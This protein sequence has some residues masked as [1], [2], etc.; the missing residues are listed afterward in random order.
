MRFALS[1]IAV[2][3]SL[4]AC[5]GGDGDGDGGVGGDQSNNT[6]VP[7]TLTSTNYV[8]VAQEALTSNA[9]LLDS[10]SLALG[11]QVSDSN[12]L[13]RFGQEQL[14]KMPGWFADAA[15]QAVGAVHAETVRCDGGGTLT[16][17]ANDLNGNEQVDLGDSMKLSANNC[18]TEGSVLNGQLVLTINRMVGSMDRYPYEVGADLRF[19]SLSVQAGSD[20]EI[21]NGSLS[22]NIQAINNKTMTTKL[23]TSSF[24][25]SGNYGGTTYSQAL[26]DYETD[27]RLISNG[28]SVTWT[29]SVRGIL[30]SSSFESKSVGIETLADFVRFDDQAYPRSGSALITGAAGAKIRVTAVNDTTVSIELDA[31]GNDSYETTVSKPWSEML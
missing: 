10:S 8:A 6:A 3:V 26:R 14:A 28:R 16:I 18:A 25:L 2:S 1:L 21:G 7:A 15:V 30:S 13:V 19:I 5:G 20:R 17:E 31:D 22:I 27:L 24:S 12:V 9:Y 29:S 11:A 4:V 23:G